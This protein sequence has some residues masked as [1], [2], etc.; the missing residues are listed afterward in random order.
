MKKI[1][2]KKGF[3]RSFFILLVLVTCI[4]ASVSAQAASFQKSK[5]KISKNSA[6]LND[7]VY[8][9]WTKI[10]GAKKYEI[11]RAKINPS[12]G[13]AGKWKTWVTTGKTSIKKK[14][15]GDYK[16]RVRAIKGSTKSQWSSAKRIF[17]ATA[18]ITNIGYTEPDV[19][20]GVTFR[21]GYLEWR[22]TVKNK[23]N[24]PMG[25]VVSGSRF[26]NQNT[27]YA[28]NKT[29]GKK[30][31]SWEAKLDTTGIAKMVAAGKTESLYFYAFVTEQEWELYKDCK[32]MVSSS[33][34][35][36]PEVEPISTQ[37]AIAYTTN[38]ADASVA[39]K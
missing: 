35:P 13:K 37:M 18:K 6:Y 8:L 39:A 26:G 23:T 3:M 2:E 10:S 22:I 5:P 32:F 34:Y 4:F 30:V 17:G 11:Q 27:L 14:A 33:F 29:T 36:N 38:Y 19:F 28:I 31:H 20:M 1:I 16:Y 9:T 12:T 7:K 21:D 25:F 24:S 15:S